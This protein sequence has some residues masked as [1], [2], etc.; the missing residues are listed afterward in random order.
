PRSEAPLLLK[1]ERWERFSGRLFASRQ[2]EK[3]ERFGHVQV[4]RWVRFSH[5]AKSRTPSS[6]TNPQSS[7][8]YWLTRAANLLGFLR[9]T[10][11]EIDPENARAGFAPALAQSEICSFRRVQ[12]EGRGT[13]RQLNSISR[14]LVGCS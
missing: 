13:R 3:C 10:S 1:G 11:C 6:A 5:A 14:R 12:P 9:P 2:I 4:Q 8:E 7:R